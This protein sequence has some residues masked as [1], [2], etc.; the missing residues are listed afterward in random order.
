ME[1]TAEP[2]QSEQA[3]H[4][5]GAHRPEVPFGQE[6]EPAQARKP[7]SGDTENLRDAGARVDQK[8]GWKA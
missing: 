3:H 5:K 4:A 1:S 6:A 2:D 7:K 8:D